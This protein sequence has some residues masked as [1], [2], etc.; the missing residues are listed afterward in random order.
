[1]KMRMEKDNY[2]KIEGLKWPADASTSY[3]LPNETHV[4][5]N[6]SELEADCNKAF[7]IY[8][9]S[10]EQECIDAKK[11]VGAK[12]GE[13]MIFRIVRINGDGTTRIIADGSIGIKSLFN[14]VNN[15]EQYVGYTYE[16]SKP[17]V[18][19][20]KKSTIREYLDNWYKTNMTDY[21]K[22]FASTRYCNDTST[23]HTDDDG[24]L[25]YGAYDRINTSSPTP[26]Y[27]CPSTDKNYGGEYYLKIGLLTADEVSFA[28]GPIESDS[29]NFYL[30]GNN[31]DKWLGTPYSFEDNSAYGFEL[32]GSSYF[33]ALDYKYAES[34]IPVLNLKAQTPYV[35]GDG[36]K[37]NPYIVKVGE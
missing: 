3:V 28:G 26:T 24:N 31:G 23:G 21:D 16:N 5:E 20:G 19:D 12:P 13:D 27:I 9:Y 34:A 1:M 25:Y 37:D 7:D 2:L 8:G 11:E 30:Y 29:Q 10:T 14:Q 36:T 17:N 33:S 15:Q 18:Q 32:S 22:I 35:S 4:Y 6:K